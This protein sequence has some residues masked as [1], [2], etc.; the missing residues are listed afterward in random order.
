MNYF[1]F[2]KKPSISKVQMGGIVPLEEEEEDLSE[3][4]NGLSEEDKTKWQNYK[5][6]ADDFINAKTKEQFEATQYGAFGNG[7]NSLIQDDKLKASLASKFAGKQDTLPTQAELDAQNI[8]SGPAQPAEFPTKKKKGLS[9]GGMQMAAQIGTKAIDAV[10]NALMGDKNF[11]AQSEAID[12]LV[13]GTASALI[14]SGNPYAI[15]SG[16]ALKGANFLTKAGGQTVE[17]FDVDIKSSG[18]GDLGHQESKSSRDFGA[19]IGLGGIFN[20]KSTERKL[21]QRNEQ[22]MMA[23]KAANI[24]DDTKFEQEARMN[25]VDN[26]I[27]NNNIALSGGLNTQLLA[28]KH[29]AK[30]EKMDLSFVENYRNF[31]IIEDSIVKAQ[32]GAKLENI[33]VSDTP[34]VIP[35]GALHKNKHDNFELDV[36]KKGI[37]VITVKDDNVETLEDIQQQSDSVVQHAEVEE[38]EVI[39]NK[40]LTDYVES[41]RKK[42]HASNE[43]DKDICLE[44]GMRL[45]KELLENTE[46][47][48]NLIAKMEEKS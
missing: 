14:S 15:A 1:D 31:T 10:D 2:F 21:Q 24:A 7:D 17:G 38:S 47:N 40:E 26:T 6:V 12:S 46:D 28:A 48:T 23:L 43:K 5:N 9:A 29:G 20:Q 11:G 4:Y 34:S 30:L 37:P 22:A 27:R 33:E 32:N 45:A 16:I 36:T 19:M 44:V 42:W 25:S 39:L 13:D 3:L 18:Y 35:S 41:M 8:S